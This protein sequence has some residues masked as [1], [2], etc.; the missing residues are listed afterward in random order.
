VILRLLVTGRIAERFA[1]ELTTLGIPLIATVTLA[2]SPWWIGVINAGLFA[3]PVLVAL[4]AG[5][6]SDRMSPRA[7][8]AVGA[9]GRAAALGAIA[10]VWATGALTEW[11]LFALAGIAGAAAT[12]YQVT[13]AAA[14]P[15]MVEPGTLRA[16]NARIDTGSHVSSTVAP[17]AGSGLAQAV[18]APLLPLVGGAALVVTAVTAARLPEPVRAVHAAPPRIRDGLRYVIGDRLQRLILLRGMVANL[19]G[20]MVITLFPAAIV[21]VMGYDELVVGLVLGITGLGGIAGAAASPWFA[22]R[23]GDG[24]AVPMLALGGA[25]ASLGYPL[26]LASPHGWDI[27]ILFAGELGA[28]FAM[29]AYSVAQRT[30]RQEI[31]PP[32]LQGRM[33]ASLMFAMMLVAPVGALA[34]GAIAQAWGIAAAFWAG[35]ALLALSAAIVTFSPLWG[36]RD[37]PRPTASACARRTP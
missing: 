18:A 22:R 27:A 28:M 23:Y 1:D 8:M 24:G 33:N 4:P 7:L 9:V 37:L 35:S 36:M 29:A 25:A 21:R 6:M 11:W 30:L 19:G 14:V 15:A 10:L 20:V 5:L 12:L 34:G 32:H 13:S 17:I 31:C 2:S 26:A 16:A 3:A